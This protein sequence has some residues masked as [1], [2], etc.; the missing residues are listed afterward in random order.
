MFSISQMWRTGH[1]SDLYQSMSECGPNLGR[2]TAGNGPQEIGNRRARREREKKNI[3]YRMARRC[4]GV[5]RF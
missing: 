2:M 5:F 4:F 1:K 3:I